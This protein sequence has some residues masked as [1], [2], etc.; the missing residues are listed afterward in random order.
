MGGSICSRVT[1]EVQYKVPSDPEFVNLLRSPGIDSQLGG[2]ARQP[3]LTYRPAR[4]HRLS[5]SI[6]GLLKR[7]QIRALKLGRTNIRHIDDAVYF[8]S[9]LFGSMQGNK[10]VSVGSVKNM[11]QYY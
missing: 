7:L 4:L 11:E 2:L 5:E 1:E 8:T 6:P 10:I 9:I 3:Y